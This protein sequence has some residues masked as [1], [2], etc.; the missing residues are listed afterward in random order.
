MANKKLITAIGVA[1]IG[2]AVLFSM[3]TST[4]NTKPKKVECIRV[5]GGKFKCGEKIYR[6]KD[7]NIMVGKVKGQKKITCTK[8]GNK[9]NCR[10]YIERLDRRGR[11]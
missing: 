1:A 6:I 7:F 4:E 10:G 9:L 3:T 11:K 5:K 8:Y 2:S